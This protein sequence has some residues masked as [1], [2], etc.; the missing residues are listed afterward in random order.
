MALCDRARS[1]EVRS[2]AGDRGE[3]DRADDA[4][5][6]PDELRVGRTED[7]AA[8]LAVERQHKPAI[9]DDLHE[10]R[11][12]DEDRGKADRAAREGCVANA[13]GVQTRE[14][15]RRAQIDGNG[16]FYVCHEA[17]TAAADGGNETV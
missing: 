8:V 7:V 2:D 5:P 10:T 4:E 12:G 3:H 9:R 16:W 17:P 11:P 13:V 1:T 6:E 14:G 15:A